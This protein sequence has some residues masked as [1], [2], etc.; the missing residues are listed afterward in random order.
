MIK[1]Q[2]EIKD[3]RF[4]CISRECWW[5]FFLQKRRL[6]KGEQI[7]PKNFKL[8]NYTLQNKLSKTHL[9]LLT[10]RKER[11]KEKEQEEGKGDS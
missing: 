10:K 7:I 4:Q 9:Y 2:I 11:K 3:K 6:G 1:I 8:V 5:Q